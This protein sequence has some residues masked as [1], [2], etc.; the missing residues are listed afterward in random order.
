MSPAAWL[1]L[2]LMGPAWAQGERAL[3][4]EA[5]APVSAGALLAGQAAEA[6]K[7]GFPYAAL[8]L[9]ATAIG[10]DPQGAGAKATE[11][12]RLAEQ[13]GDLGLLEPV[14]GKNVGLPVDAATRARMALYAAR[15][16][17][18]QGS[19]SVALGVLKMIPPDSPAYAEGK[20][21]EGV[22]LAHTGKP[23]EAVASFQVAMA[24]G[25][26]RPDAERWVTLMN[27]DIARAH[28]AAGDF[29]RAIEHFAKVPRS[30]PWWAQAQFE[31]AW[32]HFRLD[33][34]NGALSLL[35]VHSSPWFR[36]QYFPEAA[37]LEVY[38]LFLLCKF[39]AAG[40]GIDAF[41]ARFRPMQAELARVSGQ[42]EEALFRALAEGRGQGLPAMV[43]EPFL[44]E[45][46]FQ[47]AAQAMRTLDD[48]RGRLGKASGAWAEAARPL[49]EARRER[50]I[51][52]EGGRVKARATAM[53]QELAEMLGN[54]E[55]NKLDILQMESRMYERA[56]NTG[57]MEKAKATVDRKVRVRE[58]FRLWPY[59]G[60]EWADE[61]GWLRVDTKP[62]CP[63]SLRTGK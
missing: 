55:M 56:A 39:P 4:A 5:T 7:A 1:V 52:E 31:R 43:A 21:L 54:I 16:A 58:G 33:D 6:E 44:A 13:T 30:S 23:A 34:L 27:L 25:I 36:G 9:Y 46:R 47:K 10:T 48:E 59:E 49:L 18:A 20:A 38:S 57:A 24:A 15:Y 62:E 8:L 14:F 41:A 12:L 61:V 3:S 26:K 2:T 32:A 51:A 29:V 40:Q 11:A 53:E 63:E 50:L 45:S 28:Y 22:I 42:S 37:M 19:Q 17:H 35:R 60:E